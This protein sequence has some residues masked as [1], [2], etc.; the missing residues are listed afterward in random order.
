ML[1]W[2]LL[3]LPVLLW[4]SKTLDWWLYQ[5]TTIVSGEEHIWGGIHIE[6]MYVQ[7]EELM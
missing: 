1:I 5:R 6:T 3:A 7:L 2:Y 4:N